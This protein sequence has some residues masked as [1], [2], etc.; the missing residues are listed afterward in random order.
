MEKTTAIIL[1]AGQGTRMKSATPK[2]MHRVCGL[3]IVHFGVKAALDAQCTE[4]VVVVGHGRTM[5]EEYLARAFG[6][7]VRTAV[8]QEQRGTGDAARVGLAAADEGADRVLVFYGDVPLLSADELTAVVQ[9][10]SDRRSPATLSLATC[11]VDDPTGYGRV[12]RE[13]GRVTEI[14]EHR[15]LRSDEERAVREINAGVYA[16]SASWFREALASLVAD[17]A[18][19]ELYITDM[20]E[21]AARAGAPIAAVTLSSDALAGVNDRD[22]LARVEEVMHARLVRSWRLSGAT[23]RAGARIDAGVALGP[24][25]TVEA[26]AVLRGATRVERGAV[27]DVGCVLTNVSVGA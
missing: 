16:G 1:A 24:D 13:S 23:V 19:G 10:I 6:D 14:R 5:V 21:F 27:I 8:Q 7:R 18:Q 25:V 3:P 20:V 26:G 4:V 11:R 2:V 22:Q 15:D 9:P 12:L 17:N